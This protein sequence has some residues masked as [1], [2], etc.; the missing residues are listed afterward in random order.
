MRTFRIILAGAL[1]AL[2]I[3]IVVA[4]PAGAAASVG[5]FDQCQRGT[6]TTVCSGYTGGNLIGG[7]SEDQV[8]PQR[9]EL[10]V[11]SAGTYSFTTTYDDL[12]GSSH[13]IDYL[14]TYN[15]TVTGAQ[16]CLGYAASICAGSPSTFPIPSD[17]AS[18][19]PVVAGYNIVVSTHELA[20]ADRQWTLYGG[21]ITGSTVTHSGS[22]GIATVTFTTSGPVTAILMFGAHLALTG[23]ASTPRAWAQGASTVNGNAQLAASIGGAKTH[24]IKVGS[25]T[26][27]PPPAAFTIAKTANPTSAAPGDTVTYNVTVTNTGGVA[28][29]ATFTDDYDNNLTNVTTPAGCTAGSGSMSCTT[30]SLLPNGTQTFTYTAKLPTTFSSAGTGCAAGQFAVKNT[31]TFAAGTN[32]TSGTGPATATVCVS[33]SSTFTVTKSVSG[34]QAPNGNLTYVVTVKNTGSAP[35]STTW[36]DNYDDR[37]IGVSNAVSANPTGN[38]CAPTTSGDRQFNACATASLAP[39]ASQTF[40]YTATLPGTFSGAKGGGTCTSSQYRFNNA[41]SLGT[42]SSTASVDVCV[43]AAAAFTVTKTVDDE[44]ADPGQTVTYTIKVQNTGLAAGSTTWSDNLDPRLT[45]VSSATSDNANGTTCAPTGGDFTNCATVELLSGGTETFTYTAKMPTSFTGM[46]GGD[47]PSGSF[48]LKNTATSGSSSSSVTVCVG[49]SAN[50]SIDKKASTDTANPGDT[51]TYTITVTNDGQ[52]PGG[53]S[54]TDDY[55]DALAP[56]LPTS[57]TSGASCTPGSGSFSCST[58]SVDPGDSVVFTYTAKMPTSFGPVSGSDDCADG[59]YP[60]SNTATLASNPASTAVVCVA[61]SPEFRITK[62]VDKTSAHP[63]DTITYTVTVF[64]DGDAAGATSFTDDFD[65]RLTPTDPS[66]GSC[67]ITAGSNLTMTCSTGVIAAH[68]SQVFTYSATV[69]ATF[70]GNDV[71]DNG[72]YRIANAASLVGV[73]ADPA[74]AEVCVDASPT[75]TIDKSVSNNT[76]MPGDTIT[77]TVTVSNT[78]TAAGSTSFTDDYDDALSP[79]D[80]TSSPS[81][82]NCSPAAGK[83]DCTTGVIP[84]LGQQTFTYD[85]TVPETFTGTPGNLGCGANQY[86]FKNVATLSGAHAD[87]DAKTDSVVICIGAGPKFTVSKSASDTTV[88]A[89][90]PVT[91][92]ITVTNTGNAAGSTDFTDDYADSLDIA[93][94]P[95]GCTKETVSGNKVLSCSTDELVAGDHQDFTYTVNMP[96]TFT[97][98]D[99]GECGNGAY[100]VVN[101]VSI[102]GADNEGSSDGVT[103]CTSAAPDLTVKKTAEHATVVEPGDTVHYTLTVTNNGTAPGSTTATDDYA[104]GVT[105][106]GYPSACT[107]DGDVLTCAS[108]TVEAGDH[109]SFSYDATMP[110]AF[111]GNDSGTGGC[112]PGQYP[113]V[114]GVS[115][116][117]ESSDSVTTCVTAAPEWKVT[118]DADTDVATPGGTIGYTITVENTGTAS[119]VTTWSDTPDSRL[120]VTGATSDPSGNDCALTDGAFK[121]CGT[122]E[123][124][125]G[126]SQTFT[127]SGT[128]PDTFSGDPGSGCDGGQ[129][130]IHNDVTTASGATDGATVCVDASAQF[131]ITKAVDKTDAQ[132]GDT[133]NYTVTVKN[134]GSAS[135]STSFTDDYNNRLSPSLPTPD[136]GTGS[137]TDNGGSFSC[138]TGD[139]AGHSQVVFSY[140]AVLPTSYSDSDSTE[141]CGDG[142]FAIDN[143]ATLAGDDGGDGPDDSATVCVSASPDL[144]V[145]KTADKTDARPGDTISYTI[146]VTN[147]GH[148]AGSTTLTDDYDNR[149]DPSAVHR[150]ND[151]APCVDDGDTITCETGTI[152][153]GDSV[154]FTYSVV[155]PDRYTG[156]SGGGTCEDGTYPVVNTVRVDGEDAAGATVCVTAAPS[157]TVIKS[158]SVDT[159]SLGQQLITYTIGYTNLG[160]A[161]AIPVTLTDA[162]PA[163]T[164]FESCSA[165]CTTN[166]ATGTATWNV[167]SIAP[168]GGS[169]SVTLVVRVTSNQTCS[170]TNVAQLRIGNGA[171]ISSNPVT[172]AITPQPDPSGAHAWGSSVGVDLKSKGI[173]N[174]LLNGLLNPFGVNSNSLVISRASSSQ[175]GLGGPVVNNN[176]V[177]S[178]NINGILSA[179]VLNSLARSGVAQNLAAQ[180]STSEVANVCLV[181]VAGICTVQVDAVRA[182]ASTYA[183]GEYAGVSSAGSAIVGLRVTNILEPVNLNQTTKIPLNKAIFGANSYVAI[184]ERTSSA[185]LSGNTYGADLTVNMIHVKIT[186]VLLGVQAVDL[187]VGQA[188]AHSDFPK[189]FVCEGSQHQQVSGHAYVASLNTNVLLA[190]LT[191]GYVGIS[192]LGGSEKE[193]VAQ[194]VFP[195]PD[196]AGLR[197]LVAD[198]SSFGVTTAS[199]AASDSY[200]EVAGN[201]STPLCLLGGAGCVVSATLVRAQAKSLAGG[202]GSLSTD[203]GTKFVDL[204]VLGIPISGTPA[205]NTVITLPGIGFIVLNEQFCDNDGLANHSCAGT[206][207][208]GIT[209]RSIHIVVTVLNKLLKLNPGIEVIAAEAHA[210][211]AFG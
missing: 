146:T 68:S 105:V 118:K 22:T 173:I 201:G 167:G 56:T 14:A 77:Y 136:T 156:E 25:S 75:F 95:A 20:Q 127:Y 157:V 164:R 198:S 159:N 31:A 94:P 192:P 81:G 1:A 72:G 187:V 170:V 117:N 151:G 46:S 109:T 40:T 121:D 148:A 100:P 110:S 48:A 41:V 16:P 106:S 99:H 79:G 21:T 202:Q 206:H 152:G 27:P 139:I 131:S 17:T 189:T 210:D 171:P 205:P 183:T 88:S 126:G 141:G 134:L 80:A 53:T 37:L 2:G 49:A 78:G 36:T 6:P 15:Y 128:L 195:A 63:G 124:P 165:E 132:P 28:G 39:G 176:S 186:G 177:L 86:G 7:Y 208:S 160:D 104:D 122:A 163:G 197:A 209:V 92:T 103:V 102:D 67:F 178:A 155:L 83:F 211:T 47:C 137:C 26:P 61:A 45:D 168:K 116:S 147:N 9:V 24:N 129:F 153:A 30:N 29:T 58:G 57:T 3:S 181:P 23:P 82:N 59:T 93:N 125:A 123:I 199:G 166:G 66:V 138:D 191:Q 69:P 10:N 74:G 143:T 161:E 96:A 19:G 60:V 150:S 4:P 188:I 162:I 184:N 12:S 13:I 196:G 154:T 172:D 87:A 35:G 204:K 54:F 133:V 179:G 158:S 34:T 175:S 44:T 91:Y 38:D 182:V 185:G 111:D 101:S 193:H 142:Q 98:D 97:G 108:G 55:D 200:A 32:V 8:V 113:V 84:A 42:G 119:G 112:E 107:D 43:S 50:F 89:G 144:V 76:P 64:N 85:V 169:G 90:D 11:D 70:S 120:T 130:A 115:L 174:V 135:G 114:N 51:V 190:D 203:G 140:S 180:T 145:T 207:A 52:A 62:S 5:T 73:D 149:L 18:R 194:V 33:A 71:C 65:D